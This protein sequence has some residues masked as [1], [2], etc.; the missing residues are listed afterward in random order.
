MVPFVKMPRH[1]DPQPMHAFGE[2]GGIVRH[3]PIGG[4][5][6]SRIVPGHHLQQEGT[7]FHG[8]GHRA[9]VIQ[10]IGQ[11]LDAGSAPA[12]VGAPAMA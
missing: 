3:R 11:R 10:A 4:A 5:R 12:L 1:A 6:A 2:I 9:G 7:I 8:P